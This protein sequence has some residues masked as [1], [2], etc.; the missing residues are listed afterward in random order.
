MREKGFAAYLKKVRD[1]NILRMSRNSRAGLRRNLI[2][3]ESL[4]C[5]EEILKKSPELQNQLTESINQTLGNAFKAM[6]EKDILAFL[7]SYRIN[8]EKRRIRAEEEE[9]ELLALEEL[10]M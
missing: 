6:A 5:F 7:E 4:E 1:K 8:A 2:L 10:D 3:R 9:Q